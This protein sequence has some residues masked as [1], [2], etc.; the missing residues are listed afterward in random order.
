MMKKADVG[1]LDYGVGNITSLRGALEKIGCGVVVGAKEKDF[2]KKT[3]VFLPGVGC[4]PFAMRNLRE[5]KMDK[6][7]E[8]RFLDGDLEVIGICLGMQLF[9][10]HSEEGDAEDGLGFLRGKVKC[11]RNNESHVGWNIINPVQESNDFPR[12]AYYFNHSY[13]ADCDSDVLIATCN[14]Q[15]GFPAIVQYK[16]LTGVQFHPEKSQNVGA[17]IL[18]LLV[19]G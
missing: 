2:I 17:Q 16:N 15:K 11:F 4:Y 18:S 14:Y 6:F 3:H 12:H 7:L 13:Y 19:K 5:T 1:I 8:K 10:E 9:F